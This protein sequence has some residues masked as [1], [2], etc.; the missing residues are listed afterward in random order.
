VSCFQT[1]RIDDSKTL[2]QVKRNSCGL[3]LHGLAKQAVLSLQASENVRGRTRDEKADPLPVFRELDPPTATERT[4]PIRELT[5]VTE[6]S[7]AEQVR[8]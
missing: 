5:E 3:N 8:A 2:K 6:G 7:I 1:F 4:W